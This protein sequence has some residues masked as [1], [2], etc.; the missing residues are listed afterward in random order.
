MKRGR[1]GEGD[2]E[3]EDEDEMGWLKDVRNLIVYRR[4]II[5]TNILFSISFHIPYSIFETY[6]VLCQILCELPL[7]LPLLLPRC[8][9]MIVVVVV[10]FE[11][12]SYFNTHKSIYIYT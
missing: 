2:D 3:D 5:Y 8:R 9:L 12:S 7:P 6:C 4:A 11:G 10:V 1:G